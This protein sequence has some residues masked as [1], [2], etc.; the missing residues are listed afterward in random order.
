MFKIVVVFISLIVSSVVFA[1]PTKTQPKFTIVPC[2]PGINS[3]SLRQ[4]DIGETCYV[5]TNR[6]KIAR[7]LG[8]K[9]IRGIEQIVDGS[10]SMGSNLPYKTC[11]SSFLLNPLESCLLHL[12]IYG[13][14]LAGRDIQGGPVIGLN[15]ADPYLSSQ[16]SPEDALSVSLNRNS[17]PPAMVVGLT[18][19]DNRALLALSENSGVDWSYPSQLSDLNAG[20]NP[21]SPS[22]AGQASL[23]DVNCNEGTCM[24]VGSY[25]TA[26]S[27]VLRPLV[28]VSTDSGNTWRY[29]GQ[30]T[31]PSSSATPPSPQYADNGTLIKVIFHDD[32][33]MAVGYYWD[34]SSETYPLLALSTRTSLWSTWRYPNQV[35]TPTVANFSQGELADVTCTGDRCMAVGAYVAT[36]ST[37]PLPL[38]A[39]GTNLGSTWTYPGDITDPNS[40]STPPSPQF[41]S[42]RLNS[43]TC[44][45][46]L[47]MAVGVYTD[48]SGGKRPLLALSTDLGNTWIYPNQ[49]TDPTTSS[50]PPSPQ[51]ASGG[52]SRITCRDGTC[53]AAGAYTDTSGV[54]RPLLALSTDGG[55]T[56]T[57]P[58]QI[59]DPATSSTPPSPALGDSTQG[60][61]TDV[62]CAES[63]CMAAG[64]YYPSTQ[65]P[66]LAVSTDSATW[67]I[68]SYPN[69][70]TDPNSNSNPIEPP[71]TGYGL[72][73]SVRCNDNGTCMAAG[74]YGYDGSTST[75]ATSLLAVTQDGG[76]SWRFP[77]FITS[78]TS[79]GILQAIFL[80]N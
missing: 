78:D 2:F 49:I 10:A 79:N 29:P 16:P 4:H 56:W 51:F 13:A 39:L 14:K 37:T 63:L 5:V 19:T 11:A 64:T 55:S 23:F 40:S 41:S 72:F 22:A 32:I 52:L 25:T 31:D 44:Y 53:M 6:M 1:V 38:L 26:T 7:R 35:T 69:Q 50:M 17:Q 59:T 76:E 54:Q 9:P 24:A 46:N 34:S 30:V 58:N 70:L 80:P 73:T 12:R 71:F 27:A 33:S 47:C 42:G 8:M 57:Y 65:N 74:Q 20:P 75:A 68:W 62:S 36:S 43:I 60:S 61:L 21:I 67:N 77:S 15:D 66:L 18:S 48:T 45:T 3:M 28:T